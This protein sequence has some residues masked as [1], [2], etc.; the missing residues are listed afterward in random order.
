MWDLSFWLAGDDVPDPEEATA[1]NDVGGTF[2]DFGRSN[3]DR[4]SVMKKK[5]NEVAP[6]R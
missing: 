2:E 1:L 4:S 6:R 5:R 3:S